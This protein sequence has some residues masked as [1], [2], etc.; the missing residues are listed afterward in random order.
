MLLRKL[1]KRKGKIKIPSA[2]LLKIVDWNIEQ[3]ASYI[4][5]HQ[6]NRHLRCYKN[7]VYDCY[8]EWGVN[9]EGKLFATGYV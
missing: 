9:A 5:V 7:K 6:P 8:L 3:R 2:I 1:F 4:I